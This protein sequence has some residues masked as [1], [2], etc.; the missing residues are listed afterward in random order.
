MKSVQWLLAAAILAAIPLAS[1]SPVASSPQPDDPPSRVGRLNWLTGDVAFQ[2]A[3]LD[4]WTTATLNYPLTTADHLFTGQ[5]S[6]VEMHIG[7]NAVRLDSNTN[8]GFLNVDDGI[9][10]VSLTAGSAEIHLRSL[11]DDDTF[12]VATPNGAITLLRTGDYRIDTDPERDA[13]M[14]TVRAG[15]AELFSG[16]NSVIIRSPQTAYFKTDQ[17]PNIQTANDPDDFDSFVAAREG[18]VLTTDAAAPAN[19]GRG[20]LDRFSDRVSVGDLVAE[21][22]TGAEDLNAYGTWQNSPLGQDWVPPVDPGWV[23]YSDGDWSYVEPWGWTWIDAAPWG[24]APYHYGRWGFAN[25]RW[26]WYPGPRQTVQTYAPALVTFIGGGSAGSV[27][28]FPLS[29]RDSWI[30]PWRPPPDTAMLPRISSN[31]NVPG[32]IRTLPQIDFISGTRVHPGIGLASEG[33]IIGSSPLVM[34]VRDSILVGTS[35]M[36][37]P[38][39]N[40]PLIARTAPPPAPV[41]FAATLGLLAVNR[42]RPLQKKQVEYLRKTLPAAVLQRTAVRSTVPLINTPRTPKPAPAARPQTKPASVK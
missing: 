2:P 6:R 23:P 34:P 8:F 40:R 11:E 24:F 22:M 39:V 42:G 29:P 27:S 20:Y 32:A 16:A 38:V 5:D 18:T 13:T 30:P 12:E 37:P 9:V 25:G 15:Q 21:G 10:Q 1:Q 33:E 41:S 35:R 7:A 36:R 4:E 31:R 17:N 3:G 28:W 26:V 19:N 14:L